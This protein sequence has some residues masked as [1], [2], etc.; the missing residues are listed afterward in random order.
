MSSNTRTQLHAKSK[1]TFTIAC[2]IIIVIMYQ[3]PNRTLQVLNPIKTNNRN[4]ILHG[5]AKL[6]YLTLLFQLLLSVSLSNSL[7][8]ASPSKLCLRTFL[9]FLKQVRCSFKYHSLLLNRLSQFYQ[10]FRSLNSHVAYL[11]SR[12]KFAHLASFQAIKFV[13]PAVSENA[14]HHFVCEIGV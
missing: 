10:Y 9:I 8:L 4:R 3:L 5:R 12:V 11:L 14:R 7:L 13:G 2:T 1:P 6:R